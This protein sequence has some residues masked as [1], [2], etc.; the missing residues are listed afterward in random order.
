MTV[1]EYTALVWSPVGCGIDMTS[2]TQSGEEFLKVC[3]I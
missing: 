3:I 2:A 1:K